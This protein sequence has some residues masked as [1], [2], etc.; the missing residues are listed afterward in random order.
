[1]ISK[2]ILILL[3]VA[4]ASA[5]LDLFLDG[6]ETRQV[7]RSKELDGALFFVF[8]GETRPN[9]L[10][11]TFQLPPDK[12]DIEFSWRQT[13]SSVKQILQT[14][15]WYRLE[16]NDVLTGQTSPF[17]SFNIN[18]VGPVPDHLSRFKVK[19]DCQARRKSSNRTS[20]NDPIGVVLN[21]S[22]KVN[23]SLPSSSYHRPNSLIDNLEL[24]IIRMNISLKKTCKPDDDVKIVPLNKNANKS[25][26]G[27]QFSGSFI[28]IITLVA[29][30][31][32]CLFVIFV[33]MTGNKKK[34]PIVSKQ[35]DNDD[36][37]RPIM[38]IQPIPLKVNSIDC[39]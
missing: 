21:V 33:M 15:L 27:T 32:I 24:T 22:F 8:D 26:T 39:A 13:L 30:F 17:V 20:L 1:M 28:V 16:A 10:A 14:S 37:P 29:F 5:Y 3:F 36:L 25:R 12:D 35:I 7:F 6:N 9:I 34:R 23:Y 31:L 18:S 11:H 4:N 19:F 38:I 2:S